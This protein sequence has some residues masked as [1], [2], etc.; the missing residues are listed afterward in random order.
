MLLEDLQK[1]NHFDT[2][3]TGRPT[4]DEI[5]F[6]AKDY[7]R[8]RKKK[9]GV[10]QWMSPDAYIDACKEGFRSVGETGN[11]ESGRDPAIVDKYAKMMQDGVKFHLPILDYR[12]YHGEMDFSQ[13]GLHRVMA[14]RQ[15][16]DE[17]IPVAVLKDVDQ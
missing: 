5:M 11:I 13:E 8:D 1:S 17:R 14:A 9:E 15:L 4:P 6:T 2:T 7:H 3:T 12:G 10:L 16:G